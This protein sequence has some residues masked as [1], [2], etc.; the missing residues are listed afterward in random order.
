MIPTTHGNW[1]TR[2]RSA[3]FTMIEIAVS[4]AIV[5]FALV[6]VIGVLPAGMN[7]Q[8]DNRERRW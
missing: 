5:G 1:N 6:A 3:G 4:I 7:T 8:R 2:L